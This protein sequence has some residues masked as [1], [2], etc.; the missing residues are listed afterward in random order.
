MTPIAIHISA[1]VFNLH[2]TVAIE[3]LIGHCLIEVQFEMVLRQQLSYI[4][5]RID[6][7][8]YLIE[9]ITVRKTR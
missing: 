3:V 8:P 1:E 6:E 7:R 4:L 5:V 2:T 9:Q